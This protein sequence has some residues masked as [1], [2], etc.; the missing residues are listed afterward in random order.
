MTFV[1]DSRLTIEIFDLIKSRGSKITVYKEL[2]LAKVPKSKEDEEQQYRLSSM[3][4]E[5]LWDEGLNYAECNKLSDPVPLVVNHLHVAGAGMFHAWLEPPHE[6]CIPFEARLED[7]HFAGFAEGSIPSMAWAFP[8][9]IHLGFKRL[10]LYKVDGELGIK[11]LL[12]NPRHR[13][14]K[15]IFS[16]PGYQQQQANLTQLQSAVL[17]QMRNNMRLPPQMLGT[18]RGRITASEIQ[19]QQNAV[20]AFGNQKQMICRPDA[21]DAGLLSSLGGVGIGSGKQTTVGIDRAHQDTKGSTKAE[22]IRRVFGRA[23][24][25]LSE[26]RWSFKPDHS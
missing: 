9:Q 20:A 14:S 22:R 19:A 8:D 25:K 7:F 10:Y 21:V 23:G 6:H 16:M 26:A 5:K 18:N 17:D 12:E 3:M 13:M 2:I 11:M 1:V 4:Q 24:R 15:S